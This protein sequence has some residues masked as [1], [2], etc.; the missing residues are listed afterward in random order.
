MATIATKEIDVIKVQKATSL[1]PAP[2]IYKFLISINGI[3]PYIGI[4]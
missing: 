2:P 1:I 4:P 3:I